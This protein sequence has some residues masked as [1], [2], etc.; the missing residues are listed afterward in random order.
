MH[1]PYSGWAKTLLE[2]QHYPEDRLYPGGPPK[3]PYDVTAQ[4]LPLLMGVDVQA[5]EQPV[6]FSGEWQAAGD[7]TSRAA[8]AG[9][10]H[11]FAGWRST[12]PG[13]PAVTCW[14]DPA[15]GDFSVRSRT[16]LRELKRPRIGL[17]QPCT[18]N[19][20]EG[21][22]R[23]LL[24]DFGFAYTTVRNEDI[25][26][27]GLRAEVRRHYI[28]RSGRRQHRERQSQSCRRNTA[29]ASGRRARRC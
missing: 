12:A 3:R 2:R 7:G 27:G 15:T 1:Q 6:P 24:E 10:G 21:W 19:M 28:C 16:G 11:G 13:R 14:R 5:V 26:A 23:W 20:D 25:Q 9:F 4:T 8:N 17:Y 22:T 29:A 18:A